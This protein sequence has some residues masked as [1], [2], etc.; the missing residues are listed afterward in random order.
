MLLLWSPTFTVFAANQNST[1]TW[2]SHCLSTCWQIPQELYYY[3]M[4]LHCQLKALNQYLKH[5][6][7]VLRQHIH[8]AWKACWKKDLLDMSK[9]LC[10]MSTGHKND[11]FLCLSALR[12][13]ES[14]QKTKPNQG[15]QDCHKSKT[16]SKKWHFRQIFGFLELPFI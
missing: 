8:V 14:K 11:T 6:A 7:W 10:C 3:L 15:F 13:P 12:Y 16:L 1:L 4:F 2:Y 5:L 9:Q